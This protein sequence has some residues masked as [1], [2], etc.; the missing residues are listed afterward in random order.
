MLLFL[1]FSFFSLGKCVIEA[2]IN[3]DLKNPEIVFKAE[4]F[5][6]G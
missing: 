3:I 4:A 6:V 2:S 5:N 1:L